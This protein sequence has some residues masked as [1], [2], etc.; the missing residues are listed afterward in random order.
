MIKSAALVVPLPGVSDEISWS[1]NTNGK[2]STASVYRHLEKNISGPDNNMIWKAKLPLKIKVFLWQLFQ[3]AIL[4]RD[5]MRKRKWLGRP[6]CSFCNNIETV[7]HLFF[8]C[9][10]V[11]VVW[12]VLGACLQTNTCPRNVW[13]SLVWFYKFLPNDRKFYTLLLAAIAWATWTIRNKV[14]F[15]NYKMRSPEVIVY[16]VASFIGYWA[17]LYDEG[18]AAKIRE[19]AKKLMEKT[20]EITRGVQNGGA[21]TNDGLIAGSE[22]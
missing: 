1:L 22:I 8:T 2:F 7:G 21:A 6:V 9:A 3:D 15:D 10:S 18:D 19:G 13:Q 16:T 4:T 12:G 20:A 5:N 14:T 11:K 17:G